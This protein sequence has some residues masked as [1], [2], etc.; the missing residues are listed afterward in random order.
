MKIHY[1]FIEHERTQD[2]PFIGALICASKCNLKCKGCFNSVLKKDETLEGYSEDIIEKV[3][4]NKFNEGIILA[5]LEWS[6]TPLEMFELCRLASENGLKVMIYTGLDLFPFHVKIGK[7]FVESTKFDTEFLDK[8][9][10]KA[11]TEEFYAMIGRQ[12][13]DNF[14]MGDYYIKTGKY[15]KDYLVDNRE[16]FGIQLASANQNVY[17]IRKSE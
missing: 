7:A 17:L 14:I 11:F 12:T 5:G 3:A 4:E 10:L 9:Q 2:A 8:L 16:A 13:L 6:E 15:D 1:K